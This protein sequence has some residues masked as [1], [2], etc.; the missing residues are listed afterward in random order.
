MFDKCV[1]VKCPMQ[2]VGAKF[3]S[4]KVRNVIIAFKAGGPFT[5]VEK[6]FYPWLLLS[7]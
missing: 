1:I 7:G 3:N 6:L 2:I 5:G 4:S